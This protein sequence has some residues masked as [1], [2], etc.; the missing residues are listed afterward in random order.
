[1]PTKKSTKKSAENPP[2]SAAAAKR[3]K[4]NSASGSS[5]SGNSCGRQAKAKA[6]KRV[7]KEKN[8]SEESDFEEETVEYRLTPPKSKKKAIKKHL[9]GS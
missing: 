1:M 4:E 9:F 3:E 8:D 7:L 2:R 6:N 5:S